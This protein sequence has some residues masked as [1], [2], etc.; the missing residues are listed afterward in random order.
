MMG[1]V[2]APSLEGSS[3]ESHTGGRP[4]PGPELVVGIIGGAVCVCTLTRR[5]F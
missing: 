4:V 3:D 1:S 5:Q 2:C